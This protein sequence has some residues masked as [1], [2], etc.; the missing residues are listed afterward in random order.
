MNTTSV[1]ARSVAGLWDRVI[2]VEE[3]R[4]QPGDFEIL[5][6][7]EGPKSIAVC[8]PGCHAVSLLNLRPGNGPDWKFDGD[9]AKPTLHPSIHHPGCWHG[10]LTDGQFVSC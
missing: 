3:L 4:P 10:W 6:D 7:T 5:E 2:H 8:C 1:A 9:H